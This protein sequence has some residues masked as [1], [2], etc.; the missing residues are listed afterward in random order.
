MK[1]F[2]FKALADS[3]VRNRTQKFLQYLDEQSYSAY[4]DERLVLAN[5]IINRLSLRM[6]KIESYVEEMMDFGAFSIHITI[7]G[8][9]EVVISPKVRHISLA[10]GCIYTHVVFGSFR[11]ID[12]FTSEF[13]NKFR[14]SKKG[15]FLGFK[16]E[17]S[18]A[19]FREKL[20]NFVSVYDRD[21]VAISDII[22]KLD[23]SKLSITVNGFLVTFY[24]DQSA[25]EVITFD[26]L[27]RFATLKTR[28][29]K[30]EKYDI[31]PNLL[32]ECV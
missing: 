5:Q 18:S 32:K 4:P 13:D 27:N 16:L 2:N 25:Y 1:P 30:T 11:D 29:G 9:I 14:F 8:S 7:Y 15:E 26:L 31:V 21:E 10:S 22:R 24:T 12:E 28:K 3:V 20:V 17:D 6:G 19:L 23:K